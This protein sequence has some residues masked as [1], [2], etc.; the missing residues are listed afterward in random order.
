M[1]VPTYLQAFVDDAAIFPPGNAPSSRRS[2]TTST[3]ATRSTPTWSAG[4][5]SATSRSPTSRACG[6]A[7]STSGDRQPPTGRQPRRHG[8]RRRDRA[9][10]HLGR[11]LR[12]AL[13]PRRRV[14]A[15]RRGGPRPQ[16]AATDPGGRLAGRAQL[17]DVTVFAEPPVPD[18]HPDARLAGRP[19]RARRPGD[20]PEVPHRRGDRR[21]LPHAA[22]LAACIE[23]ALDRELPFKCTAG[24]HNA[25]RH[26]DEETGFEHHGFLNILLATRTCLDGG[27]PEEVARVLDETDGDHA[28][29]AGP[30]RSRRGGAH[31]TLVH[32]VRLVQRARGARG[33]RRAGA[34]RRMSWVQ[35]PP[36]RR[37]T[38]TTCRTACS[39]STGRS[40]GRRTAR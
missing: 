8:R 21:S 15:A 33:P 36:G 32:L 6:G 39:R 11:P 1:T 16:R 14:R 40:A 3:T 22:R 38:W 10:G 9:G 4:S 35:A 34:G 13:A 24:L 31:P 28:R 23:A 37:T 30:R 27:G 5:W 7:S 2:P 29:R 20:P 19:R 18:G 25:V 17:D 26:R 12:R